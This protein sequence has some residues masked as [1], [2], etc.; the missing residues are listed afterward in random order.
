MYAAL[1]KRHLGT[2]PSNTVQH[3]KNDCHHLATTTQSGKAT[4]NPRMLVVD[5]PKNDSVM[6]Y[7]T[8][9]VDT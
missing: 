4:I 5:E 1:N 6:V 3:P 2:L 7:D 8:P 9:E